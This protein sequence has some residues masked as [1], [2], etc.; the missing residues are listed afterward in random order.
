MQVSIQK[1]IFNPKDPGFILDPYPTYR[2]LREN[3]PIH[4]SPTGYWV[5]TRYEDVCSAL[6]DLR[7][8]NSPAPF[9]PVN[10][11]NRDR[12]LAAEV[13]SNIIAFLDPPDHMPPRRIIAA[14]FQDYLKGKEAIISAVADEILLGLN[15]RNRIDFVRDFS[16]PFSITCMCRIIGFPEN[17]LSRL[18]YW[19]DMFFYLFHT[20]PNLH[21]LN[22]VN[23]ALEEF[24]EATASIVRERKSK[25][26][27]D[28]ISR[29]L[30][31]KHRDYSLSEQQVID[32]CMLLASD[33]IGN[34]HTGL[35]TS[36][37]T[38][39]RHSEQLHR[40]MEKPEL[41]PAAVE[42]CLRYESPAQHQGRIASEE[43]QIGGKRIK[44]NSVVL[45]V[46]ASANRDPDFVADPDRFDI[47][48]H[49]PRHVSFGLGTHRCVGS[50]LVS[51]EFETALKKIFD[52]S[53]VVKL[54][55][56]KLNWVARAGHRW[57]E[58]LPLVIA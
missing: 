51:I 47:E 2:F 15:G 14:S 25:P 40:M 8:R 16:I 43:I 54:E 31:T 28:F 12:Y 30:E 6:N 26:Q 7:F 42:E 24:R 55:N 57:P 18:E 50:K 9:A 10:R 36:L 3:D 56:E 37:A 5:I 29:L 22:E 27:D 11:R 35:T 19:S 38:L 39:L 52:G 58:S 33:A 4:Y 1:P 34:V 20:I 46:L 13:A 41:I 32:N 44:A 48:R 21:V 17:S 23:L 49:R 45:I 53:R